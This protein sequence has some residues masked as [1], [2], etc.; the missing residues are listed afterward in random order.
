MSD[1]LQLFIT[2]CT[3]G[4]FG[5]V[6]RLLI[7]YRDKSEEQELERLKRIYMAFLEETRKNTTESQA[8]NQ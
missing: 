3:I 4:V 7:Y 5:L 1:Y 6:L 2:L 8:G